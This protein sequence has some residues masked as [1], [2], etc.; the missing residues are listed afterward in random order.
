MYDENKKRL[1]DAYR[2]LEPNIPGEETYVINGNKLKETYKKVEEDPPR[3][4]NL[5]EK[6]AKTKWKIVKELIVLI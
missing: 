1:D 6:W 3:S 5:R 4:R 2:E